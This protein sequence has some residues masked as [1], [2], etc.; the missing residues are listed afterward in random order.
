M[1]RLTARL[2]ANH[3]CSRGPGVSTGKVTSATKF[4]SICNCT[5]SSSIE[6]EILWFSKEVFFTVVIVDMIGISRDILPYHKGEYSIF[7][8]IDSICFK[9]SLVKNKTSLILDL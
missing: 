4:T 9:E 3:G 5:S 7:Q 6:V 2:A 8:D 1:L